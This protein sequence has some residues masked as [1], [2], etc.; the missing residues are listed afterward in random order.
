MAGAVAGAF[1]FAGIFEG[2]LEGVDVSY[3]WGSS[4]APLGGRDGPGAFR[5]GSDGGGLF[6][7]FLSGS[8]GGGADCTGGGAE[9]TG[10]SWKSGR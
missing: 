9:C 10:D 4:F 7:G 5:G 6:F 3:C 8:A 2:G 1:G